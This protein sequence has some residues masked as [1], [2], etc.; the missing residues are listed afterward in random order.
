MKYFIPK[1]SEKI[2]KKKDSPKIKIILVKTFSL[3]LFI[4]LFSLPSFSSAATIFASPAEKTV[5][6]GDTFTLLINANSQ[7]TSINAASLDVKY[8]AGLLSAQSIGHPSSIFSLWA[9]EPTYSNSTGVAHFSGGLSSPGWSGT[10]GNLIRITFKAKAVGQ[11]KITFQGGSVL[12]NDGIGTDVLSGTIGAT[13]NITAAGNVTP[14]PT[15]TPT[16]PSTINQPLVAG[17][18]KKPTLGSVSTPTSTPNPAPV[19]SNRPESLLIPVLENIPDQLIEGDKLSFVGQGIS[20]GQIQVYI[21]KGKEN[22]EVTQVDTKED[23]KFSIDYKTPV[24]SG[25]YRVWAKNISADGV[26]SASSDLSYVEV[27]SKKGFNVFGLE[28]SYILT[29]ILLSIFS[30]ILLA[31]LIITR[32][33]WTQVRENGSEKTRPEPRLI[34]KE[35]QV[36]NAEQV[37]EEV[38]KVRKYKKRVDVSK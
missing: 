38:K 28:I 36:E 30:V 16:I 22:V 12:A 2:V 5:K 26:L 25:Y 18:D 29:I 14:A 17:K 34:S 10:N 33:K 31:L 11:T 23:G 19:E 4:F 35:I 37:A 8:D 24:L 3:L 32:R 9:E 13:I 6:V 21:Q 1:I 15:P 20:N 7:G 27:V